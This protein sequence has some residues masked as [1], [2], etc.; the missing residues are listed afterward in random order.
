M[1]DQKYMDLNCCGCMTI[2]TDVN[3]KCMF[4]FYIIEALAVLCLA[5]RDIT[6]VAPIAFLDML[7]VIP[8]LLLLC[9]FCLVLKHDSAI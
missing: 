5:T 4:A 1:N 2:S 9:H 7:L 8:N 3:L 6:A